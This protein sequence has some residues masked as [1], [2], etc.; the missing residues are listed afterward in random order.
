M[1]SSQPPSDRSSVI[2]TPMSGLRKVR[3]RDEVSCPQPRTQSRPTPPFL[4]SPSL[5]LLQVHQFPHKFPDLSILRAFAQAV[6][7]V[8]TVFKVSPFYCCFSLNVLRLACHFQR[9]IL[10]STLS[11]LLRDWASLYLPV[12]SVTSVPSTHTANAPRMCC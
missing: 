9:W 12:C 2:I 11:P 10:Q 4:C 5:K 8:S 6:A 3:H 1:K 7:A